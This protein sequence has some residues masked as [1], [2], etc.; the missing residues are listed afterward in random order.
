MRIALAQL[1]LLVGD[2]AGNVAKVV[3]AMVRA[4]DELHAD[5]ILF[6]ELALTAYPPED[7]LLRPGLHRQ[8][9]RGLE[10]LKRQVKGIDVVIGYPAPGPDGN[11]VATKPFFSI[12][13][14]IR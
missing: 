11:G 9:L 12:N 4:R 13:L 6:P 10:T 7:L 14:A 8:V 2:V 3:S 1:N 5:L